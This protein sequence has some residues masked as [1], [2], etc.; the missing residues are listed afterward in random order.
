MDHVSVRSDRPIL[1]NDALSVELEHE[2]GRGVRPGRGAGADQPKV[3][4]K[5]A[6]ERRVEEVIGK[7]VLL[8]QL[9]DWQ[10]GR[11]VVA[12]GQPAV[13][14]PGD[15]SIHSAAVD[16]TLFLEGPIH[17]VPDLLVG[18]SERRRVIRGDG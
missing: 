6:T 11:I 4:K 9:A 2:V 16:L 8:C 10:I 18:F 5:R 13:L 14:A 15:K 17:D 1:D 7:R 12:H 3:V